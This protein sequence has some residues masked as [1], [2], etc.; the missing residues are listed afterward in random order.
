MKRP[1]ASSSDPVENNGDAPQNTVAKDAVLVSKSLF[2]SPGRGSTTEK[3]ATKRKAKSLAST[4]TKKAENSNIKSFTATGKKQDNRIFAAEHANEDVA[5]AAISDAAPPLSNTTANT[6]EDP[7]N[8]EYPCLYF[9]VRIPEDLRHTNNI[10]SSGTLLDLS[11]D[12]IE[13][14]KLL[15]EPKYILYPE[16]DF[17]FPLSDEVKS[18][19]TMA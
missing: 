6:H 13:V 17:A 1:R 2:A 9:Q 16:R 19:V 3:T 14:E 7:S 8:E 18:N 15:N 11:E 4:A 12:S 5:A 10:D